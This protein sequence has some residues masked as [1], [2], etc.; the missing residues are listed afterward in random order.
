MLGY[1]GGLFTGLQLSAGV[2]RGL[3]ETDEVLWGLLRPAGACRGLQGSVQF[4]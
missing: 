3:Q 4:N 2:Y 1:A